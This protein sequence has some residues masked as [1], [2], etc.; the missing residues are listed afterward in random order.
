MVVFLSVFYLF[1]HVVS[2][3]KRDELTYVGEEPTE[4]VNEEDSPKEEE[5]N[6]EEEENPGEQEDPAEEQD[7]VEEQPQ[8]DP[9]FNYGDEYKVGNG[10]HVPFAL[11]ETPSPYGYYMF[12]PESYKHIN[13]TYPVLIF[14][15]GSGERGNSQT[16]KSELTKVFKHG[17]GKLINNKTWSP[18]EEM[19]VVSAQTTVNRWDS[20]ALKRFI[21][22]LVDT[23]R[24]DKKRIYLTGLSLGGSGTYDYLGKYGNNS[25]IAAAVA[26]CG[27]NNSSNQAYVANVSKVPLWIFHGEADPQVDVSYAIK[28]N[29]AFESVGNIKVKPKVTLYPNVGHDSW[30]MTY[31]GSGQGKENSDYDAFNQDIYS[32]MLQYKLP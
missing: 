25:N 5:G 4:V 24:I 7:P 28:I 1:F 18:K 10:F 8:E 21:D 13:N 20:E 29:K 19:L 16:N 12:F 9:N 17:P 23:Y 2:C 26:I 22:Y 11:G 3:D 32:W 15:H 30:T 6:N 14:L 31:D 27:R